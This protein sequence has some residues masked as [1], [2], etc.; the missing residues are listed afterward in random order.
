MWCEKKRVRTIFDMFKEYTCEG[1]K[2]I[3]TEN[4]YFYSANNY[5]SSPIS[6]LTTFE[7]NNAIFVI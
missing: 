5:N 3:Y 6:T 7:N 2:F 4:E 1:C